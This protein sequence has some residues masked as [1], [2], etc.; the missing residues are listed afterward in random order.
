M[1]HSVPISVA[2]TIAVMGPIWMSHI[3]GEDGGLIALGDGK[4]SSQDVF[5]D[6]KRYGKQP[7]HP[8]IFHI[9][10]MLGVLA[11]AL[12]GVVVAATYL[13]DAKVKKAVTAIYCAW[14]LTITGVQYTHPWTGAPPASL[15]EMPAPL[16]YVMIALV[17]VGCYL[18]DDLKLKT[19]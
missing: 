13:G 9:L 5:G 14:L 3:V 11:F 10:A 6:G 2:V 15:L 17:A 12:S 7:M 1:K 19:A 4:I 16:V 8:V 18:D